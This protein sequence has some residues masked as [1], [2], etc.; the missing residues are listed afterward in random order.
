MRMLLVDDEPDFLSYLEIGLAEHGIETESARS[1]DEAKAVLEGR[2]RGHF[3]LILLDVKMPGQSGWDLLYE[4]RQAG[5]EVPVIFVTGETELPDKIRGLGLGADDFIGKPFVFEELVAR[6][7][8][9]LRRRNAL[10]TI[11]HGEVEM[12]LATRKVQRAGR[13]V[14]LSPREF[15]LLLALAR[16]RGE[17]LSREVLL[18]DVWDMAFDPSTNVLDVHIGRL[19]KKLDRGG[20]PLIQNVRGEGYRL[21]A[22]LPD[23][24]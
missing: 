6:A 9:V 4:L 10:P 14:E 24:R 22:H 16:A 17:V 8:A 5:E 18:R 15:D 1:G 2:V 13:P 11:Q 23:E 21:V 3:D 7:E 12:D 20:R 19:R